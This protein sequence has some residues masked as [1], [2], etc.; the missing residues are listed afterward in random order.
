MISLTQDAT[1]A[2]P[3]PIRLASGPAIMQTEIG[4]C[5]GV[6]NIPIVG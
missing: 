2:K 6:A 4:S 5:F 1:L 3:L